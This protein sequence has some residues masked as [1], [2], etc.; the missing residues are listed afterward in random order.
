MITSNIIIV[1]RITGSATKLTT[2]GMLREGAALS[3]RNWVEANGVEVRFHIQHDGSGIDLQYL[4]EEPQVRATQKDFNSAVY[5][6]SCVEF[7]IAFPEEGPQY[8]NFEFNC[9]G[10]VLGGYGENR[11]DR[12]QI[13]GEVLGQILTRPSLGNQP[14]GIKEGPVV[15]K[16]GIRIPADVLIYS[17]IDDLSG[18]GAS[19]NF[20]KCGD[21]LDHPHYLSWQ[22][23]KTPEP[24]FHQPRYFGK[25]EFQ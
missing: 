20:F 5:E 14:F 18:M 19:G 12:K 9:I 22:P 17:E 6:D 23:V 2:S 4:V 15:W 7:F 1:P 16:L 21:R 25:L 11:H 3:H 10:T 8:Y 24:D 13:P